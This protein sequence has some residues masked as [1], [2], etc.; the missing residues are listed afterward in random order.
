MQR[1]EIEAAGALSSFRAQG[2]F[3][4]ARLQGYAPPSGDLENGYSSMSF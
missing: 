3:K 1:S 2:R 4:S